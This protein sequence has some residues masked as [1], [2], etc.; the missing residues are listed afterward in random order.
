MMPSGTADMTCS[1]AAD[2]LAQTRQ[3]VAAAAGRVARRSALPA[4]DREDLE[5]DLLVGLLAAIAR[6][7][8]ARGTFGAFAA[9]CCA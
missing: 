6:Y 8:A 3:E 1:L 4:H 7:D 5:Q 9:G 2:R